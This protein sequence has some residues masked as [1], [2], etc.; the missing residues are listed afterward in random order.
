MKMLMIMA[1]FVFNLWATIITVPSAEYSSINDALLHSKKGDTVLVKSGTYKEKIAIPN[2]VYLRSDR[3]HG[4]ILNGKG[5]FTVVTMGQHSSL[6]GFVIK[7]GTIGVESHHA[8]NHILRC[9]LYHHIQSGIICTGHVPKIMDNVVVYNKGSGIHGW[10]LRS[11]NASIIHNTIAHNGNHGVSVGGNSKVVLENNIV[12]FN[13]HFAIKPE[14]SQMKI[15]MINNNFFRNASLVE[16]LPAGNM[17]KDPQFMKP[18]RMDFSLA[19]TS[20]CLNKTDSREQLGAR[21]F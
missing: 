7:N 4:A 5:K 10:D 17:S 18:T 19:E 14:P 16:K 11:T 13:E 21:V 20:P 8:G 15:V 3:L 12:C 6:D 2:G 9:V 1:V